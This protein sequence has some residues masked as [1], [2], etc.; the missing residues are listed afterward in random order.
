MLAQWRKY[1]LQFKTPGGTS[2]GVLR[3]KDSYFIRLE[4]GNGSV[5]YGECGI[6][7]GLS[8]DDV[9]G[10]E[11][12]LHWTCEN[13]HLG[14]EELYSANTHYPSIQFGLEQAFDGFSDRA[15]NFFPEPQPIN[16][17]IWM[18]SKEQMAQQMTQKIQEGFT[19]IKMKIG[20]ITWSDEL[21]LLKHLR[22]QFP[23]DQI[24]IRVDANGAFTYQESLKVLKE[25]A[26]L[27]VHSIEQPMKP[28]FRAEL[29]T[30]CQNPPVPIALDESLIGIV[31]PEE[32][33]ELLDQVK[34]QYIIL[35]PSFI[36]GWRGSQDWVDRAEERNIGWWSTSALESNVGL[37]AIAHWTAQQQTTMPQGL[38]TGGLYTNNFPSP[39]TVEKGALQFNPSQ[40]WDLTA[41]EALFK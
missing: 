12:Q 7:R 3:T 36:G 25:L 33:N 5:S 17:L 41:L 15:G 39:M 31:T 8:Y 29:A 2:R 37:A 1:T 28:E 4:N 14:L 9:P 30:L 13:I 32:R 26:A 34:P 6:L 27:Q 24:E 40:D 22:E 20:A 23:A 18:G 10:Y 19:C 21:A 16:G 11:S 38:G 35:K